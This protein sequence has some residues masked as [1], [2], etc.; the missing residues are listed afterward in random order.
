MKRPALFWHFP[1]R[2]KI[3]NSGAIRKG[4]FKLVEKFSTGKIELYDLS[5]DIGETTDLAGEFPDKARELLNDLRA[6]RKEVNASMPR[7]YES[8]KR[9]ADGGLSRAASPPTGRGSPGKG[10]IQP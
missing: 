4:R 2:G 10:A 5:R 3:G 8:N 6:W 9:G 7:D 1:H